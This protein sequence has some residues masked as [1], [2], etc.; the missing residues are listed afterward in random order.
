MFFAS[1]YMK[2]LK[3]STVGANKGAVSF[4]DDRVVLAHNLDL[5]HNILQTAVGL[6]K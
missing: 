2:T 1:K 6:N 3:I 5:S 4:C